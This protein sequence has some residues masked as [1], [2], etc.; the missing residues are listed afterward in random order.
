[1][2]YT[3]Q[4]GETLLG[5]AHRHGT[6]LSHIL[7]LNPGMN[8]DYVQ[9]DQV[10]I[11]PQTKVAVASNPAK[12]PAPQKTSAPAPVKSTVTT[13]KVGTDAPQPKPTVTYKE[14][15][16]KRKDTAYSLAKANGITAE[17]LMEANPQLAEDGYKLRRGTIIRIPSFTYPAKPQYQGLSHIR[18]AVVLPLIGTG[19]EHERSV[20]FYRGLLLGVDALKQQGISVAIQA[21][22]EPKPDLSVA[23][24]MNQVKSGRPDVIVGPLY[25]THFTDVTALSGPKTKVAIPFSSKVPQVEFRPDVFVINTPTYYEAGLASDL[26]LNSFKKSTTVVF[27]NR[28][29]GNKQPFCDELKTKLL[30]AHYRVIQLAASSS[31]EQ[32]LEATRSVGQDEIVFVPNDAGEDLLRDLLPK[33]ERVRQIRPSMQTALLGYDKWI[34]LSESSLKQQFHAANTYIIAANYFYPHTTASARF[35]S[36]Y[37]RWFKTDFVDSTPRMAPLGYDF[38]CGFLGG[39][40]IYGHEFSTQLPLVGTLAAQPRLQTESRFM[41][42]GNGG[43]YVCRSMWLVHFKKDLS[44]VKISAK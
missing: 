4:P 24:L 15:K 23:Q 21:Y 36:D 35:K 10:L 29:D 37:Q 44:I 42:L 17:Q 20:E 27:L 30:S 19:L 25:P 16:V 2:R 31:V 39:M 28:Q 38:S 41:S 32:L 14:Y 43:G 33:L 12:A 18:V 6:T 22:N 26:F 5:I 8:P 1:M 40:A 34:P 9:A 11:V 3:V 13:A 7:K